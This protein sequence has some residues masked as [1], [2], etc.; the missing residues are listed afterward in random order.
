MIKSDINLEVLKSYIPQLLKV[1][2]YKNR[3]FECCPYC[4]SV[5]FIKHGFFN[6][7]QRYKCKDCK[8]TFSKTTDSLWYYSKKESNIWVAFIEL[9]LQKRTLRDCADELNI[10]LVTAFY[11]RHKIMNLLNCT[12]ISGINPEKLK[13]DVFIS[14]AIFQE[15]EYNSVINFNMDYFFQEKRIILVAARGEDDSMVV[16]PIGRNFLLYKEFADKI[17]NRIDKK[18]YI[19]ASWNKH[20]VGWAKRHNKK[21]R[22]KSR[23]SDCDEPRITRFYNNAKEW[24]SPFKGIGTKY[25][26]SYLSYFILF[27]LDKCLQSFEFTYSLVKEFNFIKTE[28]IKLIQLTI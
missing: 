23:R 2:L 1:D 14:A 17:Y 5:H 15:T 26:E 24:F 4:R 11:W 16:V 28:K 13:G 7:I 27:N 18:S 21:Y 12:H 19:V 8:K 10:S 22:N 25:L 9:F 3:K 6:G 20:L